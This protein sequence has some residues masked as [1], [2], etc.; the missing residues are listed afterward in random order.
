MTKTALAE[1]H[2]LIHEQ[3]AAQRQAAKIA[4]QAHQKALDKAEELHTSLTADTDTEANRP[5]LKAIIEA[6]A[7]KAITAE[8]AAL[9]F[10]Q[11]AI[12]R[13]DQG[14]TP[15]QARDGAF[16]TRSIIGATRG[17]SHEQR[18]KMYAALV[19]AAVERA[20]TGLIELPKDWASLLRVPD[21]QAMAET[22]DPAA[23]EKLSK[24]MHAKAEE[25]SEAD[26]LMQALQQAA[27]KLYTT[28]LDVGYSAGVFNHRAGIGL[29]NGTKL[30]PG[31]N[32]LTPE[33]FE[34]ARNDAT[35]NA[36][37]K[38]GVVEIVQ[39]Q[40]LVEEL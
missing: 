6:A 32:E 28:R 8:R 20:D 11:Y 3:D 9:V 14:L 1:L 22:L 36:Y 21:L 27:P 10:Q 15:A 13:A 17:Y 19:V 38:D 24:E 31:H 26:R 35:F 2:S 4:Q 39:T 12:A 34:A 30:A 29:K 18:A 5:R 37:L 7:K 16:L 40:K 33:Q 25:L 23:M